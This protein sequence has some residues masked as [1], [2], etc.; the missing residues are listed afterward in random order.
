MHK[1]FAMLPLVALAWTVPAQAG[2]QVLYQPAPDWVMPGEAD[3]A[4]AAAP[5]T[6]FYD[7]QYRLEG[8]TV[9]AYVDWAQRI[10][11]PQALMQANT[12]TL[13]WLPDK[14]DLIVHRVEIH[15]GDQVIDLLAQGVT[16][17]VLRREQGLEERLLDGQL[18]AS[19]SVPGLREGDVLRISRTVTTRDQALGEQM[20]AL[21]FL[22]SEPWQVGHA[23]AVMSWP[24][25]APIVW[26]AEDRVTVNGPQSRDGY[27]YI[28]VDLP[29]AEPDPVPDD[30]PFRYRRPAVLRAGTF[31]DWQQ[32]SAV[33]APYFDAAAT[34]EDGSDV[35]A[36]ARDIMDRS[37]DPLTRAA[38]AV[39][40][41]QDE[42]S[43]LLN[44]LD[45]GNYLPQAADETWHV[46]YGDCKAKTVLL[47]ALLRRMGIA[48]DPVLVSTRMGDAVPEVLPQPAAFDHV[49]VHTVIDGTELWLDGTSAAT[50]LAT[51][52]DVPP[53]YHALPLVAGGAGLIPMTMRD[54]AVPQIDAAVVIDHSAGVD[55]PA[56]MTMT[57]R[58]SG[59]AAA[60]VGAMEDAMNPAMERQVA[61]EL[62]G[63]SEEGM[64]VRSLTVAYDEEAALGT[65]EITGVVPPSFE[66]SD[67]RLRSE[68]RAG[69]NI[70]SFNPDR[71]RAAWRDIPVATRGPRR[72]AYG[73][74]MILPDAG[75][76]FVLQGDEE[77][78]DGFGNS[79]VTRSARIDGGELL[80]SGEVFALLGEIPAS[81]LPAA[82]RAARRINA[83]SLELVPPASVTW[84]WLLSD[85]ERAAR[86]APILA[87]YQ[88]AIAFAEADDYGPLTA[89]ALF[90]QSIYRFDAALAD[91]D[92]L[93]A[94]EPS[95]WTYEYRS[96]L[97]RTQGDDAAALADLRSAFELAPENGTARSI[98]EMLAYAGRFDEAQEVMDEVFPGDEEDRLF[99]F[100]SQATIAALEGDLVQARDYMDQAVAE[101]P[102]SSSAL[103]S[104]CWFRGLFDTDLDGALAVCTQAVERA[105]DPA[106]ALDSR[107]LIRFRLG[108]LEG[109]LADLDAA[110][111]V[112]PGLPESHY[113]RGITKLHLGLDGGE[114][115]IAIALRMAPQLERFYTRHGVL[116]P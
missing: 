85:A 7:W 94:E 95:A 105:S 10:D 52:A 114:E 111:A 59:P 20:Q 57:M 64:Q 106:A 72:Q 13:D 6:L 58:Y 100:A 73:L 17:D 96:W 44:G 103:N 101:A 79:R 70:G 18:T 49:I 41:V 99:Q 26:R 40:L 30:A 67:G 60:Q 16:F 37:Q 42:V 98:A 63:D 75:A 55:F 107:G 54:P 97:Q 53:F 4:D 69:S 15:R 82:R 104:D 28:E 11:N 8:G 83:N 90:L 36:L 110:L 39:R 78:A 74:R 12:Q 88:D 77:L 23:R 2:E 112:S 91:F 87:A 43:Y 32:V 51:I 86:A 33:M 66:W 35:A 9:S 84:R 115:D 108:D 19:L 14:G 109:T 93:V 92:V 50:R 68:I 65:I 116:R 46:R 31:A 56:L 24:D 25:N 61:A 71:A 38:M 29:L 27:N 21:Q 102:Q 22:P 5:A 113:L 1:S 89:R 48:A 45:G 34:V 81:D 80:A 47:L 62:S 3:F 76:G